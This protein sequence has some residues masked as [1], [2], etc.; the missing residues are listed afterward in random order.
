MIDHDFIL[1][2][3]YYPSTKPY[4][5]FTTLLHRFGRYETER[6]KSALA[7]EDHVLQHHHQHQLQQA[8]HLP[9]NAPHPHSGTHRDSMA[10]DV[11]GDPPPLKR[12]PDSSLR[13]PTIDTLGRQLMHAASG[14][15][16]DQRVS[17][18]PRQEVRMELARIK[19]AIDKIAPDPV[20]QQSPSSAAS[21]QR[22][23]PSHRNI[24]NTSATSSIKQ[25]TPA[26][27]LQNP[28]TLTA[29]EKQKFMFVGQLMQRLDHRNRDIKG[30]GDQ[31]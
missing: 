26:A 8:G 6:L 18:T 16:N 28:N 4:S 7:F 30:G 31:R 1:P 19:A 15:L 14:E 21:P 2:P 29:T 13:S 22:P 12:N 9:N 10:S 24:S 27:P 3:C 11:D 5:S 20:K 17:L 25:Q 23:T